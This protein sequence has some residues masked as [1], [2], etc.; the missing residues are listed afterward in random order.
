[1][2]RESNKATCRRFI[3]EVFNEGNLA[4]IR[5]FVTPKSVHH[6][7]G[8]DSIPAGRSPEWFADSIDFYRVAFPD[9]RLE[10]QDQIAENDRVVTRLRMQGTQK[11]PLVGI[12]ASGK[13]VDI[14]GIRV[15]RLSE[16]KIAESWFHW[17]SLGMLQQIGALPDLN[18]NPESAQWKKETGAVAILKP[19]SPAFLRNRRPSAKPLRPAA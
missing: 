4:S 1:M 5:D 19:I 14:T 12:G 17:D 15:D 11:G 18:R 13:A 7:L 8:G 6:E 2:F 9:L 10:I 16:G 3:R